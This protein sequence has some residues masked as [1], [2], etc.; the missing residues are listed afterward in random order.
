MQ[1]WQSFQFVVDFTF[2]DQLLQKQLHLLLGCDVNS[3]A[4]GAK[5]CRRSSK[6]NQQ[7]FS[8]NNVAF[9]V[10]IFLQESKFCIAFAM[11]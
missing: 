2:W 11:K 7:V 5:L 8:R 6:T 1:I 10:Y 3:E 4:L 9:S